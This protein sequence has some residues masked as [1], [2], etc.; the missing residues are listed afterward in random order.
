MK[1]VF[2][3]NICCFCSFCD[4]RMSESIM[5]TTLLQCCVS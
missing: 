3:Y 1:H 5:Y 2:S 4:W